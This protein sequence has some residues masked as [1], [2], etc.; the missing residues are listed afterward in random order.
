MSLAEAV[1]DLQALM[2]R[3]R[4]L[5]A[6]GRNPDAGQQGE[7]HDQWTCAKDFNQEF[8]GSGLGCVARDLLDQPVGVR[9]GSKGEGHTCCETKEEHH[10][11]AVVFTAAALML[12]SGGQRQPLQDSIIRDLIHRCWQIHPGMEKFSGAH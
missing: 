9:R 7:G 1:L 5:Q 12:F 2:C 6:V 3:W 10:S 4:Q 11:C 8:H